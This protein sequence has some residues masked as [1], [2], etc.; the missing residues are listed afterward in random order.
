MAVFR[1]ETDY[2]FETGYHPFDNSR[3]IGIALLNLKIEHMVFILNEQSAWLY[4]SILTDSL[5]VDHP[6]QIACVQNWH[7][8][9]C[10]R[11]RPWRPRSVLGSFGVV[12]LSCKVNFNVVRSALHNPM[13]LACV[14]PP[15]PSEKI[16]QGVSVGEG[17]TVHRLVSDE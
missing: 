2:S 4:P 1:L 16:G 11:L 17:A 6:F 15:L 12:L 14:Q 5:K 8:N 9:S 3:Q 7:L 10:L 13:C